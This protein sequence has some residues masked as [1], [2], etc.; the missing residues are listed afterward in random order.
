MLAVGSVTLLPLLS[1]SQ[2]PANIRLDR[3]DFVSA[4]RN[5]KNGQI[6]IEAQLSAAGKAKLQQLNKVWVDQKVQFEVAGVQSDFTLRDQIWGDHLE[7]GPYSKAE[8]QRVIQEINQ[9]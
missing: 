4:E 2:T 7:M 6:L 1:H 8:A 9:K 5:D 3:N